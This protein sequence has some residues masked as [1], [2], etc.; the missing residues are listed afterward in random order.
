M[1]QENSWLKTRYILTA[2][3]IAAAFFVFIFARQKTNEDVDFCRMV[4]QGMLK[5]DQRVIRY[6]DWEHLKLLGKDI[7]SRYELARTDE[8]RSKYK[9]SFLRGVAFGR[10]RYPRIMPVFRNWRVYYRDPEKTVVA[11]DAPQRD[12]MVTILFTVGKDAG[13]KKLFAI[14]LGGQG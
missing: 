2:A 9:Q 10:R 12:K 5:G 8:E 14:D 7:G 4:W 3:L 13:E 1:E 11:V 6:I